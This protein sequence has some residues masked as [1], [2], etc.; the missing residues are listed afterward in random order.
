MDCSPPDSSIHGIFQ[1]RVLEWGAIAF[2]AKLIANAFY[3]V[4][5]NFQKIWI[6]IGKRASAI[7]DKYSVLN[8]LVGLPQ[9]L[10]RASEE[11]K[12]HTPTL[13]Q[14][15]RVERYLKKAGS[16]LREKGDS[17]WN[18]RKRARTMSKP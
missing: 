4:E 10:S 13:H 16:Q 15:I 1:A 9:R 11:A 14:S 3:P 6:F 18:L 12:S 2:S 5:A 8:V 17:Q 7:P